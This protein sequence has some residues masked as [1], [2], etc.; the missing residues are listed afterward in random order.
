M[1]HYRLII[2]LSA[3]G[4]LL[5]VVSNIAGGNP[6]TAFTIVSHWLGGIAVGWSFARLRGT[7]QA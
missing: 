5:G 7:K 1:V 3:V 4:V 2:G 6:D